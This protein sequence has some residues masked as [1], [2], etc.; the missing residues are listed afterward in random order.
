MKILH[1]I[2]RTWP[3]HGGAERYV[4]EHALA[5]KRWGHTSTVVAT[6]AW[7]MSWLV[8]K[9][10]RH[11]QPGRFTRD[12][13]EIIRFPVAHP[14]ARNIF[15]AVFRRLKKGGPDRYFYPNPFIPEF[16]KWIKTADG[17]DLVHAN[18]MPFLLHG[19]YRYAQ[20]KNV[21]LVSV[22]H[23]NLGSPGHRIEPLHYFA[24]EQPKV[25]RESVLVVA[26]NRFEASVYKNEC[27][28][29]RGNILVLGSGIDPEE[30]MGADENLA[31]KAFSIPRGSKIVLSVTAH[32]RDKGSTTLLDSSIDLWK[33]GEDFILVLAG[34]VQ[35]DFQEHLDLRSEEIP[36]GRLIVTGYIREEIRKHLFSAA[37]IVAAPSRLDAFGIVLLDGWISGK[38]VIGC[39]A[40]GMPDLIEPGRTGF[41]I[42]F[43][44]TEDLSNKISSL[45]NNE[46]LAIFMGRNGYRK[47]VAEH[48]W[49]RVTDR[50]YR[51]L[52]ERLN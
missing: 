22:P 36:Q 48:T 21:P 18:A 2:H 11:L 28:V 43:G 44:D 13:I 12:G 49:Q 7:D 14:P 50:F 41:L 38:P 20:R 52:Q 30:W 17:F 3:Y 24:G 34:P 5:G 40:G 42:E 8:S 25:L 26:Q 46:E 1:L 9:Q 6:D 19:G 31:R 45:L 23:A 39:N 15:R 37:W 16:D 47:T 4:W 35:K 51:N 10:G 27:G 29:N 33:R 32:C